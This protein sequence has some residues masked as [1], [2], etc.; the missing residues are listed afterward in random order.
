MSF[1]HL[2]DVV[3][4]I[5]F[6]IARC[7]LRGPFNAVAPEPCRNVTFSD[8][9]A[10]ALRR[11]RLF[12]MPA[13]AVRLVLGEMGQELLLASKRVLPSRLEEAGFEFRCRSIDQVLRASLR[14]GG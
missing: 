9:L 7:D 5:A 14:P 6:L 1:V 13:W 3:A 4:M 11:P 10:H 12:A 8:A 2:D